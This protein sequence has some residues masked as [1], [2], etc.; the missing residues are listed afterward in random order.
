[1]VLEP[2]ND[3]VS[4]S[5]SIE[6][7]WW[8]RFVLTPELKSWESLDIDSWDFIFSWIDLS[9]DDV[10]VVG[11]SFGSFV[12]VWGDGLAMSAPWGVEL[13]Q[14]FFFIVQ[15]N[16]IEGLSN[17]DF[18][19]GIVWFWDF[20]RFQELLDFTSLDS[21]EE[22]TE[23]FGSDFILI[24]D[25]FVVFGTKVEDGWWVS[26]V[27]TQIFGK[28]V[29]KSITIVFVWKGEDD[30]FGAGGIECFEGLLGGSGF[31]VT[32][33]EEEKGRLFILEDFL[34]SVVVEGDDFSVDVKDKDK[35]QEN[36]FVHG[37]N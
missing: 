32:I 33:G 23:V 8:L 20:S 17:D 21:V 15:D 36:G 16:I 28:S 18:D 24:V 6:I 22:W 31:V 34:N 1:M 25:V 29:E 35:G 3:T 2:L 4:S 10:G 26:S 37:S 19:W 11:K 30:S 14:D 9:D 7:N 12:E 13:N 27:D 5:F